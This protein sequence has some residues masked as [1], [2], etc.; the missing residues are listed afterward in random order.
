MVRATRS[1]N[2][3]LADAGLNYREHRE[4]VRLRKKRKK[5]ELEQAENAKVG[6]SGAGLGKNARV[7]TRATTLEVKAMYTSIIPDNP[8]PPSPSP[9]KKRRTRSGTVSCTDF[10]PY[11]HA[12][13]NKPVPQFVFCGQCDLWDQDKNIVPKIQQSSRKYKC[14]ARHTNRI[15]PTRLVPTK[16]ARI[17]APGSR[18]RLAFEEEAPQNVVVND[19]MEG[20]SD[21]DSSSI[22]FAEINGADATTTSTTTAGEQPQLPTV[23][24]L[25]KMN[26]RLQATVVSLKNTLVVKTRLIRHLRKR[27]LSKA[28]PDNTVTTDQ[29]AAEELDQDPCSPAVKSG[30]KNPESQNAIFHEKVTSM[31]DQ[32][33]TTM[34]WKR[35]RVGKELAS[36]VFEYDNNVCLEALIAKSKAWLRKN[37]YTCYN[38]L[39]EMDRAGGTLGYE[40][41]EIIRSVETK[42]VKWYKGSL[43]PSIAE[44][45]RTAK[46]VEQLA[47][48]LAPFVLGL[49]TAG[50]KECI[51]F[52]PYWKIMGTVFRAFGLL[53]IG[54]L[55]SILCLFSLDGAKITK[56]LGHTMG[57]FKAAD[58]SL[59]CPFTGE[60]LLANPATS[61][62][63]SRSYVFP[64]YLMMGPETKESIKEFEPMFKFMEDCESEDIN[65]NPMKRHYGLRAMTCGANSD[66]SA[67][68]KCLCKGGAAKVSNLPC[69]CC[70]LHKAKWALG[71]STEKMLDCAWCQEANSNGDL[72]DDW[73]CYHH[74]MMTEESLAQGRLELELLT[75]GLQG[76][77]ALI[78]E[79][80]KMQLDDVETVTPASD[81]N[82]SSIHHL[83]ETAAE[84][85]Q[86]GLLLS[87]EL[88]LRDMSPLGTLVV[89]RDSLLKALVA[90]SKIRLL[91][92][93][94]AH[95]TPSEGAMFLLIQA[96]PCILHLENRVGIKILTM[97]FIEGLS[98]AK[99]GKLYQEVP[100]EGPRVEMF[101]RRVAAIV[102]KQVLGTAENSAEWQCAT[103]DKMKEIGTIQMDNMRTRR[104]MG[105]L[106]LLVEE[107]IVEEPDKI[108]WLACIPKFRDGMIKL[109]SRDDFDDTA[110]FSFQKDMDEFFQLW[111]ELWGLEGCT[112]YIHMMS[113][114][115]L[116]VYLQKWKNLYRHSQQGWEAFNSLLKTFYF[117]RTQR[118]GASNAGRGAKSRL[119]P[120]GR[121]LQR[122]VIWLCAYDGD[123]IDSWIN[124][125]P[126][127]PRSG[128]IRI[129]EEQDEEE[130]V[131]AG[132]G[133]DDDANDEELEALFTGNA[134]FV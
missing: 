10:G 47:H 15:F 134:G 8:T 6:A 119:L 43:I 83:P 81:R 38:I 51:N 87:D 67:G 99:K 128:D 122:R 104:I 41:I 79:G 133:G 76:N 117:R 20:E 25:Q 86:F 72:P 88:V 98:N 126:G 77:L 14:V 28:T 9:A 89:K 109:R 36:L 71:N 75:A 78:D 93:E 44:F 27:L 40:G 60:L 129:G 73:K 80:S 34:K 124:D 68:W 49:T 58:R 29:E 3:I 22:V 95:G 17:Q 39:R 13:Y 19:L 65:I 123:F 50:D 130:E 53:G 108:K 24:N 74:R 105:Q 66:L 1:G 112:N 132:G 62:A 116:S 37:V 127:A 21:G 111:V 94:L 69:H 90:E 11:R 42:K 97:L 101:F 113:S 12:H 23:A 2:P 103:D 16:G 102:N 85:L 82:P 7:A 100:A 59:R 54:R 125:N 107:C 118:G 131:E 46:K 91:L 114:G 32:L 55:K 26:E 64:L 52:L 121:W 115:H 92:T 45:K 57:G 120:I 61:N 56:N 48:S 96:I 110:I 33:V 18:R 63:Q 70:A 31:L 4:Q 84:R 35:K 5:H 30:R 106:E